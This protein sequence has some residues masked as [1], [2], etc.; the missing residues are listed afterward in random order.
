MPLKERISAFDGLDITPEQREIH[1]AIREFV[2]RE[3]IPVAKELEAKDEFPTKI[4]E[5]LRDMGAFGMRIPTEYGGLGLDL[6]TYALVIAEL[7]RGW[8]AVSGIVNGQYIVGG[9]I[10]AHGSEE[11]KANYL[12]RL[13]AGDIRSCFSIALSIISLCLLSCLLISRT[14]S[15]CWSPTRFTR[16][17]S[18]AKASPLRVNI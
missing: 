11:Q 1:E 9:M 13:A 17:D 2:D 5:G 18:S 15:F 12:P 16:R 3:I 6:V 10:A 14:N 8:M 7:T 4:V